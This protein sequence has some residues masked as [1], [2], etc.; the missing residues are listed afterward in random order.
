M[1][2]TKVLISV[3][4]CLHTKNS[5]TIRTKLCEINAENGIWVKYTN[6]IK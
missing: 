4:Y 3:K 1:H 6:K 2:L 5:N